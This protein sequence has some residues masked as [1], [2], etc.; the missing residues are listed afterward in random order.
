MTTDLAKLTLGNGVETPPLG[1]GVHR[2][3]PE[4]TLQAVSMALATGYR[5]ID[6]AAADGNEAQVG[7][8]VRQNGGDRGEV[9][10]TTKLWISDCWYDTALLGSARSVR[11]LGLDTL[12]LYLLHK[13]MPTES[14]RTVAAWKAPRA[15]AS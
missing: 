9:F 1:L 4:E 14:E 8:A 10:V 7:E 5:L 11:K 2:S 13:P 15:E 6:T 12:G 3:G